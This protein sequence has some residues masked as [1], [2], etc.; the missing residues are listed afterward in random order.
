MI[1]V[2]DREARLPTQF[3]GGQEL[4]SGDAFKEIFGGDTIFGKWPRCASVA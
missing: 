3:V 1:M 2:R 4:L